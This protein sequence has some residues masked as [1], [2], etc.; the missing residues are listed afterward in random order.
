MLLCLVFLPDDAS[1]TKLV[2]YQFCDKNI[3]NKQNFEID[4]CSF[5]KKNT[6]T[7]FKYT[8][9]SF[10]FVVATLQWLSYYLDKKLPKFQKKQGR[11]KIWAE[12]YMIDYITLT[13]AWILLA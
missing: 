8:Y 1:K 3:G 4:F 5:N 2:K 7:D 10:F 13:S 11:I 12:Y 9:F 6:V